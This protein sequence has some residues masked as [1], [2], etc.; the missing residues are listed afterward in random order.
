MI[1]KNCKLRAFLLWLYAGRRGGGGVRGHPPL[2]TF[3]LPYNIILCKSVQY[4]RSYDSKTV[5]QIY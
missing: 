2:T 4:S 5:K 3:A 1:M